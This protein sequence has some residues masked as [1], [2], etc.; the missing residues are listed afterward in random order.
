ME[1]I[2]RSGRAVAGF[3]LEDGD[4]S[5]GGFRGGGGFHG[6]WRGGGGWGRPGFQRGLPG[7]W[8]WWGVPYLPAVET[9]TVGPCAAWGDPVTMPPGMWMAARMAL[10]QSGG[11]P[12]VA[13]GP[14][15]V[16][17]RFAIVGSDVE[18]RPCASQVGT[19]GEADCCEVGLAGPGASPVYAAVMTGAA[20]GLLATVL[21]APLWGAIL[22]GAGAAFVTHVGI[23]RA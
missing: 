10:G 8:G 20:A 12:T 7:A 1:T 4:L 9:V 23:E 13:R 21:R 5:R 14:D 18:V 19:L 16:L 6:G 17:Y 3:A 22:A 2:T 15:G 11:Q